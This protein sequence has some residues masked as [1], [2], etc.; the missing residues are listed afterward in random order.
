MLAERGH[1]IPY[2]HLTLPG[3][4][5]MR[6]CPNCGKILIVNLGNE[7]NALCIPLTGLNVMTWCCDECEYEWDIPMLLTIDVELLSVD[8]L[9]TVPK[10]VR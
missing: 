2:T 10:W 1:E 7:E 3:I 6:H 9:S 5:F 8:Q 4:V